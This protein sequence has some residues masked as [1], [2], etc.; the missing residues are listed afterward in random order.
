MNNL[1]SKGEN[2]ESSSDNLTELDGIGTR[3][4]ENLKKNG[5]K[6]KKELKN[7]LKT[8]EGIVRLTNISGLGFQRLKQIYESNWDGEHKF[9]LK[10]SDDVL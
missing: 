1:M 10:G 6:T 8:F 7:Q 3:L 5:I 4:A 9:E 2:L